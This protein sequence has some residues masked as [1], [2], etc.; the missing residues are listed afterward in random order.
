MV[1][2][3]TVRQPILL[4]EIVRAQRLSTLSALEAL[5]VVVVTHRSDKVILKSLKFVS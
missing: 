1:V 2:V 4:V 5:R 3:L